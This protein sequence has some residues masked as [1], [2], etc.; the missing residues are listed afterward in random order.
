MNLNTPEGRTEFST[1]QVVLSVQRLVAH[2][3][4]VRNYGVQLEREHSE[5]LRGLYREAQASPAAFV[6]KYG[7]ALPEI[8]NA[9]RNQI[10]KWQAAKDDGRT[11]RQ[12]VAARHESNDVWW[13]YRIRR[14][15]N[16]RRAAKTAKFG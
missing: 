13:R 15:A 14:A 16:H 6:A 11:Q 7:L 10:T 9:L 2:A 4:G 5:R 12:L 3:N 1:R 8:A